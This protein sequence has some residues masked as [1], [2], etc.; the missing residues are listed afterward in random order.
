MSENRED[1]IIAI[2]SALLKKGTKQKFSLFFLI[3][4]SITFFVLDNLSYKFTKVTRSILNDGIYIVS[5]AASSPLKGL[6]FTSNFMSNHFSTYRENKRLKEELET[7]R[8]KK[9]D[10][11]YLITENK[12]LKDAINSTNEPNENRVLAK[13][14]LDKD[15]PFTKSVIINKGKKHSIK[16]GMP[17]MHSNYLAGRI[18]EVNYLSSRVLLLNDLNSRIPVLLETTGAQA[19]LTGRNTNRPV[20]DYL[21]E[22]YNPKIGNDIFSSGKDGF[23]KAGLPIGRVDKKIKDEIFVKLY[24]DSN[25]LLFVNVILDLPAEVQDIK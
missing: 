15:S 12:N 7:L 23:F 5:S 24:S 11:A 21:P 3:I 14:I 10:V 20:L 18:I 22:G 13:V 2:R 4:I 16:I 17:V 19:I 25:Q 9:F 1:F 6:S 8:N